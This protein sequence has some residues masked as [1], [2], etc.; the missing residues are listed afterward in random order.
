M[1]NKTKRLALM[2]LL[3]ALGLIIGY[4]EFLIPIPLGIPGVKPGFANIV[5]V[6]ALYSL[7]PWEALMINGMR[8][9]LSG[10]LFGNFSMILYS[11]AGAAVS[12]LC[13][14][15]AKKSGLFSMT[16]VSMIGGVMHNMGQLL[17]AMA[18]LETVSL[19]YYGPVLLAAGV[20]T[21]LLIGIVTGEVKKRIP[22]ALV[23]KIES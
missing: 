6:W 21:G 18:V 7:G 1:Q 12:F 20:I 13:M 5:I 10:F 17:V 22:A 11:L 14:C 3:T 8:I 19:V 2:G 9:F 23:K 15:L 16:G 4:I